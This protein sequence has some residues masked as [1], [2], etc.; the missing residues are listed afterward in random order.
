MITLNGKKFAVND[1]EFINSLFDKNGT[2]VGYYKKNRRTL[3][4]MDIQKNRVGV[5]NDNFCLC[6]AS[7]LSEVTHDVNAKGYWYSYGD[8]KIIGEWK[9]LNQKDEDIREA[10]K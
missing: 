10:F 2:C 9:N 6:K 4:L 1:K 8:I 3:I 5:I 7:K